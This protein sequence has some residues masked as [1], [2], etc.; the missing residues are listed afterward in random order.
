VKFNLKDFQVVEGR[1]VDLKKRPTIIK[2]F[3]KSR[4]QYKE[5][6]TRHIDELSSLQNILYADDRYALLLIFQAM[7]AAGK[8]GAIKH[9]M[10]GVNPQGCQVFSFKHPSPEELDHDFLWRTTRDLPQRG[11]IG[12]FNR[13]YYEEV[14]IVRVHPR[15]LKG[16]QIPE[17]LLNNKIIWEERYRSI[18]DLEKHLYYNG[19]MVI[20]FFLHLS[21]EEQRQR[22]LK[23][24]D[25]PSKNW[26]ISPADIQERKYWKDYMKAYEA[27]LNATSTLKSP[28]YIVPADDK[29]NAHLIISQTIVETL[30]RL[31]MSYPR[32]DTQRQKDLLQIRKD[33]LK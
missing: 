24:L 5:I 29:E 16:E 17:D 18:R 19:T 26:K 27:C 9:V 31:K 30:R 22:F 8:D 14:L 33:L 10:S 11:K 3:Y 7:D 23:R 12:I 2:P 28:W 20:K 25:D 13:S 6:L 15:I 4:E 32:A 21:K 1:K